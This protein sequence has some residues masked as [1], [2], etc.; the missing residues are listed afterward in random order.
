MS[1]A[2]FPYYERELLYFRQMSQDFA[3]RYPGA[4]NRLLLESNRSIDPHV[5]RMIQAF[6]LLTAR[7]QN[8]LDDE[9]PELSESLASVFF[10]QFLAPVPSMAIVEFLLDSNR[11]PLPDG[12]VID[13][14][15]RIQMQ[16]VSDVSCRYRTSYPVHLWPVAI[17]TAEMLPPPFPPGLRAPAQ[18]ASAIVLRLQT[19]AGLKFT[20][21][22][23]ERLRLYLHGENQMVAQ[24]YEL[25]FN[26]VI[27]VVFQSLD[28]PKIPPLALPGS[29]LLPVGFERD[30]AV[31]PFPKKTFPG[32]RLLLE[33]F[34]FPNKFHFADL[35]GFQRL[36]RAGFQKDI[37]V[38]IFLNRNVPALQ[39]AIDEATFRLGCTPIIN[40]FE[41]LAEPVQLSHTRTE[42]HIEPDVSLPHGLE[43]YSI[44]SVTC[45]DPTTGTSTEVE[46]FFSLRHG[47]DREAP[48][49]FW[50]STRRS[51]D[52]DGDKGTDVYLN[53]VD[54]QFRPNQP[55]EATLAV[56]TTCT[57]RHVPNQLQRF[58][59]NLRMDLEGAAP[60]SG[61]RCV[62]RPTLPLQPPLRRGLHWRVLS[63]LT[64]NHLS[65]TDEEEGKLALQ[66]ILRVYDFV[67][68]ESADQQAAVI[69]NLIDGIVS[70]TSKRVVGRVGPR[71][72]AQGIEI[73]VEFD[74]P[75]YVGTGAFLVASVLERFF[76]AYASLNSFTQTV[77]KVK[78]HEGVLK[79]W[80]PR[81]GDK[82][83]L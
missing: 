35:D 83:L 57:N 52:R 43:I 54:L 53:F 68:R 42:Y 41:R 64:L 28:D 56:R 27:Q 2:L 36:K 58:A 33:L 71:G 9:F 8:K 17:K 72:I 60:L 45:V 22:S 6:A 25:L 77:A 38:A 76:A 70:V 78:Q 23:L 12:F 82:P 16:P 67:T 20:D 14:G 29:C 13:K 55:A 48:S 26:N 1:D 49:M 39:Q 47:V 30:E 65:I 51:A 66:E 19:Q 75:K 74:E 18:A 50:H 15:S 3:R 63:Q 5:E 79:R 46:P 81:A 24:L 21:L 44:D 10:P 32:Y 73:T 34:S 61:L 62:R 4:A 40:L 31:I 7:I 69:G 37:A 80:P 59:D 11:G